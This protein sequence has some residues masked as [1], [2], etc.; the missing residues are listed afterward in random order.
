MDF[1]LQGYLSGLA[2]SG[3]NYSRVIMLEPEEE[4]CSLVLQERVRSLLRTERPDAF[5]AANDHIAGALLRALLKLK[6]RV[7][8]DVALSG[9]DNVDFATLL[10]PSLTTFDD[11]SDIIAESL[12]TMLIALI[13]DPDMP[14]ECRQKR[15][16]PQLIVRES[17]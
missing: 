4:A 9:F 7:P 16:R 14:I 2:A 11:R 15:I 8:E 5:I 6:V 17:S 1:R 12:V 13:R 10:T 3:L